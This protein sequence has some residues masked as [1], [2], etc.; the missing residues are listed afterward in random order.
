MSTEPADAAEPGT[1]AAA[2]PPANPFARPSAPPPVPP[3][4]ANPFARP[5]ATTPP[6]NPFGAAEVIEAGAEPVRKKPRFK[7]GTLFLAAV[8]AGPVVGAGVG[9]AI[10][11]S[12]PPTPLPEIAAPK[13]SYPAERVDAKA[14][15]AAG[16]QPPDIDGDLRA[17]LIERPAGSEDRTDGDGDGWLSPADLAENYGDSAREFTS[18]LS[19]GFRRAASVSWKSGDDLYQVTLV[20]YAPEA[21]LKAITGAVPRSTVDSDVSAIPGNP[22][23]YLVIGKQPLHY[24]RSTDT[25]Y[26]GEALARKGNVVM[27][28]ALYAKAP[29][30]RAQLED[31]ARRQWEKL[32]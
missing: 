23:S 4:P 12:R 1:A 2:P 21:T 7:V 11:A 3:P 8:L 31:I 22:D 30:D 32:A 29:V 6:A 27:T 26:Y 13:L 24:A 5:S 19:E 16:P 15:A 18:M 25:Y 17:L 20:Q 14:L 10:Q 9:Y 28:V